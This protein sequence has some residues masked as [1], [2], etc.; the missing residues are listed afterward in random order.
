MHG[1]DEQPPHTHNLEPK[2]GKAVPLDDQPDPWFVLRRAAREIR[3]GKYVDAPALLEA[4]AAWLD[5]EAGVLGEMEPFAE[6]INA[7]ITSKTGL[8]SF[9]VFGRDEDTGQPRMIL[10]T[11]PAA[12]A[13]AE[14]ILR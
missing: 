1:M 9:I 6:V 4:V 8:E 11:S 3:G 7:T 14:V 10:D 12:L 13:V 2:Y 5:A